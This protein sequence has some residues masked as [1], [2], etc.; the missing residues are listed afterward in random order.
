MSYR[1][2]ETD[3]PGVL[4]LTPD[5]YSDDR[6]FFFESYSN[7]AFERAVGESVDFIQDNHSRSVGGVLRGLH[8]QIAPHAQAKLVRC[9]RGSIWDV[10]VDVRSGSSTLGSWVAAEL[11]EHNKRQMWIPVG[12][13]HGFVVRSEEA[14]V[15]YK[16]N[17]IYAPECERSLLWSDPAVGIPWPL[18]L[19]PIVSDKDARAPRLD[20]A[21]LVAGA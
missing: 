13:A 3:L 4:V 12:F 19:D 15:Q 11:T 21:T 9:T 8:Y 2:E 1:A 7:Q 6:G 17:A 5:V 14:E 20:G 18:D 10:V 16:T